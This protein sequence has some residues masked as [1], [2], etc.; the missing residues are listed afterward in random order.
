M[1]FKKEK[2]MIIE[3]I[4]YLSRSDLLGNCLYKTADN[5][6][7]CDVVA[8]DKINL[9]EIALFE[10]KTKIDKN[11]LIRIVD[12]Y[13]KA[14]SKLKNKV[15]YYIVL[16]GDDVWPFHIYDISGFVNKKVEVNMDNFETMH[17]AMPTREYIIPGEIKRK[18]KKNQFQK[19]CEA[20]AVFLFVFFLLNF[21]D[22]YQFTKERLIFLGMIIII[23]LLPFI[24]VIK[25]KDFSLFL[26]DNDKEK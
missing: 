1:N 6:L 10:Y 17:V 14:Y 3:L 2:Q 12:N 20:Y 13:Q 7:T 8:C 24:D 9:K 18:E 16:P 11:N 25:Y 26:K 21:F 22:H 4:S 15:T 23:S 19:L 5:D